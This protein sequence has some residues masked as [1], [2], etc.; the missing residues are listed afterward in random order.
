MIS[1]DGVNSGKDGE[2]EICIN[3]IQIPYPPMYFSDADVAKGWEHCMGLY[4]NEPQI[5]GAQET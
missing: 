4:L 2:Y 3:P 5:K 1:T